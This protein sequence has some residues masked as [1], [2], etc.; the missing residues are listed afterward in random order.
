MVQLYLMG[1]G[2]VIGAAGVVTPLC[3][4]VVKFVNSKTNSKVSNAVCV[5]RVL[6]LTESIAGLK[7]ANKQRTEDLKGVIC[8]RFQAIEKLITELVKHE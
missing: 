6:R 5:E 2:V 4:W 1:A 3:I 7:E 8:A